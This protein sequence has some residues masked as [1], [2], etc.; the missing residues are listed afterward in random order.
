MSGIINY[1]KS[2]DEVGV[3]FI[4]A[5]AIIVFLLV[6]YVI[7]KIKQRDNHGE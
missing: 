4:I 5:L 2:L 7:A 3:R 1:F 6:R